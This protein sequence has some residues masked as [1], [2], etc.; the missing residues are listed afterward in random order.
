MSGDFKL[1][2]FLL[3][4]VVLM[5]L[6]AAGCSQ[7]LDQIISDRYSLVDTK[8]GKVN[9]EDIA[10]VFR[11]DKGVAAVAN[12]ITGFEKPQKLRRSGNGRMLMVYPQ[13]LVN[14][15]PDKRS[16]G[17]TFI[18]LMS[19]EYAANN[20]TAAY[21][22]DD[23]DDDD[24]LDDLFKTKKHKYRST[25]VFIAGWTSIRGS[26]VRGGGPGLGK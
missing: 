3:I 21:F 17:R 20:Y 9:P 26:S 18:E 19:M 2:R 13:G 8:P 12:E 14:L 11:A 25:G 10:Y 1:K 22:G 15:Y 23:W 24:I 4:A 16:P 6:M 7:P 5:S